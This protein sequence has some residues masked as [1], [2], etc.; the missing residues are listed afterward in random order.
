MYEASELTINTDSQFMINC[1]QNWITKW[2]SNGWQTASRQPVKNVE[3]MK[4]LD[5]L[6]G[7]IKINWVI[8]NFFASISLITIL[9]QH[10]SCQGILPWSQRCLW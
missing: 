3:D 7:S 9:N 10:Y 5:E 8:F 1:M 4:R 2:K 6:C